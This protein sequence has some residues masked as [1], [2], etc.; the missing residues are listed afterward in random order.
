MCFTYDICNAKEQWVK[1]FYENLMITNITTLVMTICRKLVNLSLEVI[2]AFNGL[3][4]H[5][6]T[7]LLAKDNATE[8]CLVSKLFL[9][10]NVS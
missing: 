1:E 8:I 3:P 9:G 6:T 7:L 2:N 10:K 4:N 5:E